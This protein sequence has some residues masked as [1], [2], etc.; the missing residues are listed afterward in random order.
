M[1]VC[2]VTGNV[3]GFG[4]IWKQGDTGRLHRIHLERAG[5]TDEL[6]VSDMNPLSVVF[7]N[8]MTYTVQGNM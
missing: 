6:H 3:P 2:A 7:V 4:P 5:N 8:L 1:I